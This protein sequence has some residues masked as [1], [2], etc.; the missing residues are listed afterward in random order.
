MGHSDSINQGAGYICKEIP[1]TFP[2][3]FL[4]FLFFFYKL[5]SL[6]LDKKFI[7][8]FFSYYF[9]L[10]SPLTHSEQCCPK[11]NISKI[12]NFVR[13]HL[14]EF[15]EREMSPSDGLSSQNNTDTKETRTYTRPS[16]TRTHDITLR[17]PKHFAPQIA[18][19]H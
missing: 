4:L 16:G 11:S 12:Y 17:G 18:R 2:F 14:V 15:L 1:G 10:L 6:K 19:A 3:S 5:K 9:F 8:F 13:T 7:S